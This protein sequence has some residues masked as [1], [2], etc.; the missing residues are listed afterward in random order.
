MKVILAGG[1]GFIGGALRNSLT[2]KDYEVVILTRQ[3]SR[4]NEPGVRTRFRYWNPPE[5]G[6]W[7]NELS[8]AD[9]LIN[10]SGEP[11]VGKRWSARQKKKIV[12]SRI[13]SVRTLVQA[14]GRARR[15]P[16]VFINASSGLIVG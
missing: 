8:D 10:L 14:L 6:I 7:E 13:Q 16:S 1:T 3:A 11:I 2:E 4:E 9:A 5:E 15:R 12:E